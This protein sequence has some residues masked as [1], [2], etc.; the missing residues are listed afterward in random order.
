M[1]PW[2][3]GVCTRFVDPAADRGGELGNV[4]T[5]AA[6]RGPGEPDT[7]ELVSGYGRTGDCMRNLGLGDG[8]RPGVRGGEACV[9]GGLFHGVLQDA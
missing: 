2:I 3:C 9:R 7:R 8:D 5:L 1:R 4:Y 6:V